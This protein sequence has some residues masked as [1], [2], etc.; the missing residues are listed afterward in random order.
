MRQWPIVRGLSKTVPHTFSE[1]LALWRRSVRTL[2]P[3]VELYQQQADA[4]VDGVGKVAKVRN[5]LIHGTWSLGEN[6]NGEFLVVNYRSVRGV[7]RIDSLW[8]GKEILDNLLADVRML[9]GVI[10]GFTVTKM[11]HAHNG[12]LRA[13]PAPSHDHDALPI[14]A[15]PEPLQQ[16]PETS[17]E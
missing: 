13:T 4:F 8:V 6:E 9:S 3:E 15:K 2:Y 14:A 1:R 10:V 7:D 17:E 11:I 5:H 16:L 12:L